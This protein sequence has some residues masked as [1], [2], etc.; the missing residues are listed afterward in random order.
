M[1]LRWRKLSHQ[2][3]KMLELVRRSWDIVQ[4]LWDKDGVAIGGGWDDVM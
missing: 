4:M 3:L 1:M 2:L